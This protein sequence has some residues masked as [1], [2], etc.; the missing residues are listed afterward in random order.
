MME[1]R[2]D[3]FSSARKVTRLTMWGRQTEARED[4]R[5]LEDMDDKAWLQLFIQLTGG[6]ADV[7]TE[8][9]SRTNLSNLGPNTLRCSKS[10]A[11]L[12]LEI[13]GH[14]P[15]HYIAGTRLMAAAD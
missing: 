11:S 12:L 4:T 7:V 13:L 6:Y 9:R 1:H 10:I 3:L 8:S 5:E 15:L 14:K 2:P